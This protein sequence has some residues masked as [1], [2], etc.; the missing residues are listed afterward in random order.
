MRLAT[1]TEDF[2][3]YCPNTQECIK[4]IAEAGFRY[5][6]LSQYV[7]RYTPELL[8][9]E[10][11]REHAKRL[12]NYADALGVTFIQSHSPGV[13]PLNIADPDHEFYMKTVIRS[14]EVCGE[15][16]IPNIVIHQGH[17]PGITKEE[18]FEKNRAFFASLFPVMEANNVNVLCENS[19]PHENLYWTNSGADMR[20]FV[21]YV[22]HPLFHAC[23]DTGHG[24]VCGAQYEELLTLGDELYALHINDNLGTYDEHIPP[25]FG[26]VN[27]DEIMTA[28]TDIGYNGYFTYESTRGLRSN[29]IRF[30]KRREFTVNQMLAN[31]TLEMQKHIEKLMYDMGV[32]FLQTY[33]CF[34]E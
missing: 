8:V 33:N 19:T 10:N 26:T 34:E 12:K 31:P 14:I 18:F 28:L 2:F 24:N 22:N 5:V 30:S 3:Q 11:W 7:I 9:D 23:W 16:G 4:H 13:N 32:Y 6:D 17:T 25:Y 21:K 29:N 20:E 27:M 1:T 15:L